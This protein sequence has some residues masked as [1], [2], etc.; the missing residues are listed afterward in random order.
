M[1]MRAVAKFQQPDK[2]IRSND[3]LL[4]HNQIR[5]E[6]PTIHAERLTLLQLGYFATMFDEDLTAQKISRESRSAAV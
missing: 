3:G 2:R 4:F 5:E 6:L 1:S